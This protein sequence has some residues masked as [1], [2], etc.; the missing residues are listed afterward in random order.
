M[1]IPQPREQMSAKVIKN[2]GLSMANT[3]NKP[4]INVTE[5]SFTMT[6]VVTIFGVLITLAVGGVSGYY[7]MLNRLDSMDRR[8]DSVDRDTKEIKETLKELKGDIKQL[9]KKP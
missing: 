6:Q 9:V 7:G 8:F 5:I 4:K 1:G 3:N 2:K